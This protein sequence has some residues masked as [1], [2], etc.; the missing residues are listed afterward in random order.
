MTGI[1]IR[2]FAPGDL[3]RVVALWNL[4]LRKDPI[5][6]ERFWQL[7]LLDPNF[8]PAGMLIAESGGM[9]VGMLQAMA[10]KTPL[11]SLGLQPTLGWI[12]VFFVHPERRR[13]GI[14]G[15]LLA[16][17]LD[18]L[19]ERGRADVMCNGYAPYYIFPGVDV[20]Y[21][22]AQQF[23]QARGFSVSSESVAMGMRLEGVR[24]PEAV[25]MR[26]EL[27]QKDGHAVRPFQRE[28]TLPIL[29][30]AGRH[31][32]HWQPSVLEGL[33]RGNTDLLLATHHAEITGFTQ[34]ENP[35]NDPPH[36]A[37]GRFGPFGIRD[38]LRS[39]GIGAALFY[40]LI[41]WATARGSRYLWFG[42]AGGRNLSFYE[43]A[44]CVVTRRFRLLKRTL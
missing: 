36:G 26:F 15:R 12:T 19:R 6:E 38:D 40:T 16:A 32:P 14:G 43:R 23:L 22:E 3:G 34:W 28:D 20:D 17:G 39:L 21:S 8:D 44:G 7:F 31:F 25:R 35:H 2:G 29:D 4:C 10:R 5:A 13:E 9:V 30:F 42:W 18:F 1:S 24:M 41:E 33:Q 27:L 11:G 37:P